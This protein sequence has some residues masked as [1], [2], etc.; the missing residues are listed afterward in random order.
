[1][2]TKYT[3]LI[4]RYFDQLLSPEEVD[5]VEQ[6]KKTDSDFLQEFELFEKAHQALKLS[7]IIDLKAEIKGIHQKMDS[8][9]RVGK[10]VK[11]RWVGIAASILLLVGFGFYAQDFSNQSLYSEAF[12]PV[13]DYITNMDND[14]S[15]L[16]KAMELFNKQ[17]FDS[18]GQLFSKIYATT[19]NQVALFYEGHAHYQVGRL[20]QAI[21]ILNKVSNNYKPEAQW[22]IALAHLKMGDDANA[23]ETL[24]VIINNNQDEA[25]VLKAKKLKR[26]LTSPIRKLVF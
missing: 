10:I 4:E 26:K 5:K 13:G 1:M 2:E 16:E 6:L 19:G 17:Q 7:T 20:E 12:T 22:Y 3:S 8:S 21:K 9:K 11:L 24:N 18:S 15:E 14:L 25:F 23:I